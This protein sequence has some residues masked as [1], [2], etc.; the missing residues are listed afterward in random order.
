ARS[1]WPGQLDAVK[2]SADS[3]PVTFDG[4]AHDILGAGLYDP[5]PPAAV[6]ASELE[7][8]HRC[9][10]PIDLAHRQRDLVRVGVEE[11]YVG[12]V[13]DDRDDVTGEQRPFAVGAGR[14]VK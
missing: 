11:R 10:D 2:P 9:S 1:R 4:P 14:P 8:L 5:P 3:A 7:R 6:D 12:A 13:G